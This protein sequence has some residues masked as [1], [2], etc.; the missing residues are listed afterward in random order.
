MFLYKL[1]HYKRNVKYIIKFSAIFPFDLVTLQQFLHKIDQYTSEIISIVIRQ[2][3]E[4]RII[5]RTC[6]EQYFLTLRAQ[7]SISHTL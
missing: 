6:I 4:C 5:F 1:H 3:H 2:S 7:S